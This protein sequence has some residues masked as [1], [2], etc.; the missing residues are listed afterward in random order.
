MLSALILR[1]DAPLLSFGGVTVDNYGVTRDFPGRSLLTGLLANAMG[2][3]HGESERLEALQRRIVYGVRCDVP[4]RRLRDFQTV[5]LAQPFLQAGWTT[6]GRVQGRAGA[7]ETREGTH[8]RY[9][10]YIANAAYTVVL[11]LLPEPPPTL[12]AI[13]AALQTPARPLFIGRKPCLPALPIYAGQMTAESIREAL[14]KAPL[15]PRAAGRKFR[16]WLPADGQAPQLAIPIT[17]DRDWHN[18][19]HV[20]RRWMR[21]ENIDV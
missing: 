3:E 9:R 5:D 15:H 2:Y 4:G 6:W 8:I 7:R 11:T 20:G 1:L 12:D 14:C 19:I 21:E 13:A 16:A 17:D 10:D 18:Q